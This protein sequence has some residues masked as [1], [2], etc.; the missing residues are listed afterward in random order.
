[1]EALRRSH[2]IETVV[3]M[4]TAQ[5]VV[6]VMTAQTV[7]VMMTTQTVRGGGNTL[8]SLFSDQE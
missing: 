4:M 7:V 2:S 5:T 1:M 8:A 3:V 6:V